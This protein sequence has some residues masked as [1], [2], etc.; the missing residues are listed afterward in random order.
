MSQM[1]HSLSDLVHVLNDGIG[2]YDEASRRAGNHVYTDVF[3][4]MHHLKSAI[5]A[6]L[7]AE[8]ALQGE[9][10]PINGTW[11]GDMRIS[12]ADL[13]IDMSEHPDHA[14]ISQ[15]EAQEDRVLG[16]FKNAIVSDKSERVREL[17]RLYLPEVQRMHDEI[18]AL[19]IYRYS[20]HVKAKK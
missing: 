15:V 19:K 14:Y 16:A 6:D 13:L 3:A 17:A 12:Y 18:K 2:F 8:I 10:P 20:S 9:R 5:V 11:L 7:N 1:T 4:R